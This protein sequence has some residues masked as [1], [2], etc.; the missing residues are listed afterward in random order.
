MNSPGDWKGAGPN[1]GRDRRKWVV[2]SFAAEAWHLPGGLSFTKFPRRAH[3][4]SFGHLLDPATLNSRWSIDWVTA[5]NASIVMP[6]DFDPARP[7][8][9]DRVVEV[10]PEFESEMENLVALNRTSGSHRL[11]RLFIQRWFRPGRCYRV[12]D[13]CTGAGDLPRAMV[14]WARPFEITLRIDAVDNSE[15]ALSLARKRCADFPEVRFI[16]DDARTYRSDLPY[17]LVH[18]SLALHHFDDDDSVRLLRRAQQCSNRW[19]LVSD[20]ERQM[21]TTLSIWLVTALVY[22]HPA[23]VHDGR[24]SARRAFSY[25]ELRRLAEEAGWSGFGHS[26]FMWCRQAIWL[27]ET[28]LGEV[29]VEPLVMPS[30]A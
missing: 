29:P 24:L 7:E 12:L 17:D 9:M 20:L 15:A 16:K 27:D 25:W 1:G 3:A 13:L 30:P 5:Y 23:T 18:C 4:E 14:E 10:T 26:R 28:A 6:R 2:L 22:T 11:I 8:L 19:V 21:L